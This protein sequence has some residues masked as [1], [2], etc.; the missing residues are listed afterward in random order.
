MAFTSV[1]HKFRF[2]V[3]LDT[4]EARTFKWVKI[5]KSVF[6]IIGPDSSHLSSSQSLPLRKYVYRV[7][8]PLSGR[9]ALITLPTFENYSLT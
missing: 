4:A 6:E 3:L 7:K 2:L 5:A 8:T 9:I 1:P